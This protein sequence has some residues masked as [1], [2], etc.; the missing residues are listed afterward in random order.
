MAF[1]GIGERFTAFEARRIGVLSHPIWRVNVQRAVSHNHILSFGWN[2]KPRVSTTHH[3]SEFKRK[4]P[5]NV[6]G[7]SEGVPRAAIK[8]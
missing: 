5:K 2:S 7:S 4:C 1:A 6:L 3:L 8:V